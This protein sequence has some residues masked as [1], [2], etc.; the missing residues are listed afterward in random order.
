MKQRIWELDAF[1]GICLLGMIYCHL[2]YDI[3]TLLRLPSINDGGIFDLIS[4]GGFLFIMLSGI[5]ATLGKRPVKRGLIVF[6]CGMICTLVT[7]AMWKFGF[8]TKDLL[9]YFGVLHCIGACMLLWPV[10]RK[11]P[12]WVLIPIGLAIVCLKDYMA[13]IS[14][15]SLAF[16]PFG[17]YPYFFASSDYFPLIPAFGYF[18]IGGGLG[19][20]LYKEKKSL[21]PEPRFFPFNMLCFIGRHSLWFYLGH[22]PILMGVFYLL[23]LVVTPA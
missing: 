5:C 20:I 23:S 3:T 10:F 19:Q 14:T 6:G 16:I 21:I 4:K 15:E 13:T 11:L 22:Q 8:A 2:Y 18:L 7:Y 17:V 12:W 1:R 9:I